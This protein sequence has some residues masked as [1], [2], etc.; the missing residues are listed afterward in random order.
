MA[1]KLRKN[2]RFDN[3]WELVRQV[4][5]LGA[6]LS[7]MGDI[8]LETISIQ[9]N[10]DGILYHIGAEIHGTFLSYTRVVLKIFQVS[11]QHLFERFPLRL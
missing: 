11:S 5:N 3:P 10:K 9:D 7:V 1:L 2:Q 8:G 6:Y 4:Y